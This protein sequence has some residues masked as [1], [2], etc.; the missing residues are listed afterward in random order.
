MIARLR[1]LHYAWVVAGVTFLALLAA[2]GFRSTVGVFV[3]PLQDEFGWGRDQVSLAISINLLCYGLVAPFAAALVERLGTRRV[4]AGALVA[5]AAGSALTVLMN[6]LWQ[7]DVLWG[8]VIGLATGSVSIPLS[9]IVAT[10]W[11]VRHRG[12]VTGL[13]AAS[14]ATGNLIF[15]PLLAWITDTHGW[16]WAAALVAVVATAIVPVALLLMRERPEDVGLLPLGATEPTPPPPPP[17][18]NPFK[19]PI[20][21]L[22]EAAHV[23]DFWLLA[24]T[25][26]VCGWTTNGAVQSHFI[27]AAHDHHIPEV[28]A[29]SLLALIGLFDIVG[30]TTSGWLTDRADPRRLLFAYYSLRGISLAFLPYLL[31]APRGTLVAFAVLYGLDWVATVPPTVALTNAVFGRDKAG[32]VFGWIFASHM[33]GGAAAA[34]VAGAA[35]TT[36]GNYVIAFVGGGIL[37]VAAGFASLTIARGSRR[38]VPPAVPEP[39]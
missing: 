7:L 38:I 36:F 4:M 20:T 19:R 10:R 8:V 33:V 5:I 14:F 26:F 34:Y 30:S 13:M 18:E 27:P 2:A 39:A 32:V 25:F 15:L 3:V 23:R 1:S 12:L 17:T 31:S 16:R 24:G 22:R 29:A 28:T 11:F 9:A 35:R 6:A 37:A 21:V